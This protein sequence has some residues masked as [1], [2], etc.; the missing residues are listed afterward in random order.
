MTEEQRRAKVKRNR[1]TARRA[2]G[3]YAAGYAIGRHG[4]TVS[5]AVIQHRPRRLAKGK[6]RSPGGALQSFNVYTRE[7]AAEDWKRRYRKG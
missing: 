4:P 6:T 5:Q 2:V 3:A 7:S 1:K